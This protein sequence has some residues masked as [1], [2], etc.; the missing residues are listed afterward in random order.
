MEDLITRIEK[1]EQ[2]QFNG[3][4]TM[5]EEITLLRLIE[6]AEKSLQI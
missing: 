2:K 5:D 6:L 1:L 3:S 4:I